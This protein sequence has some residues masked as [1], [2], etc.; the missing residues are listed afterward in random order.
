[1]TRKDTVADRWHRRL[2][3]V[4][5]NDI[6]V[7][8]GRQGAGFAIEPSHDVGVGRLI[9]Q[10]DLDG[11]ISFQAKVTSPEDGRETAGSDAC[12]DPIA[13]HED[14]AQPDHRGRVPEGIDASSQPIVRHDAAVH[15][16]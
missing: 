2:D 9:R 13:T 4:D 5:G 15:E 6:R 3:V 11:H 16:P 12:V 14:V 8:E 7:A 1:M 10:Q